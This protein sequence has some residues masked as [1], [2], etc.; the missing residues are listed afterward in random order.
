M[1]NCDI[2]N[3]VVVSA[4]QESRIDRAYRTNTF[5][6]QAGG[7]RHRVALRDSHIEKAIRIA[8][9]E[10]AGSSAAGHRTGDRNDFRILA[11]QL[12]QA[13]T[14]GGGIR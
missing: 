6:C 7:K 3:H 4:L 1:L 13:L 12:H 5:R 10:H 14:K 11:G 8:L 9:G 2:V